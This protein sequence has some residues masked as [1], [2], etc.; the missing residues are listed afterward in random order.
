MKICFFL[1]V[2]Y[3][4]IP[5]V[6]YLMFKSKQAFEVTFTQQLGIS[7]YSFVLFIPGSILIFCF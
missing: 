2:F 5:F 6:T 1:G 7:A 3:F 4:G